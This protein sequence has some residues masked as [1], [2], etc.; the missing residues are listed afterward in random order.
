MHNNF[1]LT[2]TQSITRAHTCVMSSCD[3]VAL[4]LEELAP[5]RVVN[6]VGHPRGRG[7]ILGAHVSGVPLYNNHH[8]L[9][10][11]GKESSS[12]TWF[13]YIAAQSISKSPPA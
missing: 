3:L 8:A 12:T 2:R 4:R 10:V 11:L 13:M 6:L 5:S 1:H 7:L 9:S